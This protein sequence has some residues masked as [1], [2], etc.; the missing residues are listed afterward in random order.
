L[1]F[2]WTFIR[3]FFSAFFGFYIVLDHLSLTLVAGFKGRCLL[4]YAQLYEQWFETQW[5]QFRCRRMGFYCYAKNVEFMIFSKSSGLPGLWII[6]FGLGFIGLTTHC[7]AAAV[8]LLLSRGATNVCRM[9]M[10]KRCIRLTF[11]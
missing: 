7:N 6:F 9:L 8:A 5:M 10:S 1:A 2:Y 4:V 11:T 3:L